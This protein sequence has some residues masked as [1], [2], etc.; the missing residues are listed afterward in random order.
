MQDLFPY[1]QVRPV[2]DELIDAVRDALESRK[3]LIV[4]APT[5]L[6]KT[7]GVLAPALSHAK[8]HGLKVLFLTS[9]HTQ[10]SL[11]VQTLQ[12]ISSRHHVEIRAAD[13][14]GKKWMC[15]FEGAHTLP[16]FNE[17]CRKNKEDGT[18]EYYSN[19]RASGKV[20]PKALEMLQSL[21]I[22]RH[23]EEII[24]MCSDMKL[25]AYEMAVLLAQKSDVIVADYYYAF[26]P[27]V[28]EQFLKRS[29]IS[30]S[31]C[32]II[33]DEAHN[34]P[35]RIR[36]LASSRLTS[37]MLTRAVREAKKYGFNDTTETLS[38]LLDALGRLGG[39]ERIVAK[40]EFTK[41][42]GSDFR[43]M[44]ADLEFVAADVREAQ[45]QSALGSVSGFLEAWVGTDEGYAR[46][47][48]VDEFMGK[49]NSR[50]GR[51]CMDPAAVAKPVLDAAYCTIMMSGTL[52]PTE[53][54]R[55]IMGFDKPME[56][57]FPSPFPNQNRIN[58]VVPKTTTK[59][60]ARSER[61]FSQ[62]AEVCAE[63]AESV[64]G[65]TLIFFPSYYIRDQ[66]A[67][68]LPA[69]CKKPIIS[70]KPK[71]TKEEKGRMLDSFKTH[72]AT[73]AVMLGVAAGSFSE[74]IDL[75]GDL[76]KCVVI[77]GLP[78]SQP[79]LETQEL[80][81]YYETK[82]QR[83]WDY[84]YIYPAFNKALQSAGR[85]IRSETDKGA[86]VFLDER[87]LW[88]NYR[89]LFPRD[90]DM[91]VSTEPGEDISLFFRASAPAPINRP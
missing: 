16:D 2:Q 23:N 39:R 50:L 83:G 27:S 68:F 20:T 28:S 60:T 29:G 3:D 91:E 80:I 53:M 25:C 82:F 74:G 51:N 18:C 88:P 30:L 79:D 56:K 10:H 62:I 69:A 70:E 14:I 11:A 84:G 42:V 43:Q 55:D 66:V 32:I 34:L 49:P 12:D 72:S 47:I 31:D 73:G 40:E 21:N 45:R 65:N 85:C 78:L 87:Y 59:Y 38:V 46:I 13:M 33:A 4:H 22:I 8:A 15:L 26:H 63:I 24:S 90:W 41:L 71:L 64:P 52:T 36:D 17:F 44:A 37:N 35:N 76:L 1:E 75:P 86:I 9:R 81:K 77:V 19:L 5:G 54:Y 48:K 58:L 61:Q 67:R 6:G 57:I 89:R 7:A